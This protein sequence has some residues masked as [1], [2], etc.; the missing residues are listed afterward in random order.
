MDLA[1]YLDLERAPLMEPPGDQPQ[2]LHY[3]C[4]LHEALED[5]ALR[6]I[7]GLQEGRHGVL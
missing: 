1:C 7:K 5:D 2:L 6:F 4:E 3:S